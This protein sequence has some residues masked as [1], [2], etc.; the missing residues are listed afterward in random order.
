MTQAKDLKMQA[1]DI[2]PVRC[3]VAPVY[4]TRTGNMKHLHDTIGRDPEFGFRHGE[5][6]RGRKQMPGYLMCFKPT[7]TSTCGAGTKGLRFDKIKSTL[8]RFGIRVDQN[9]ILKAR[10]EFL[11][12]CPRTTSNEQADLNQFDRVMRKLGMND[13]YIS[14]RVFKCFDVDESGYVD[15]KE[16]CLGLTAAWESTLADK[17]V[18][19]FNVIDRDGDGMLERDE[20]EDLLIDS[21]QFDEA[22]PERTLHNVKVMVNLIFDLIDPLAKGGGISKER[23]LDGLIIHPQ[24]VTILDKCFGT[25]TKNAAGN[26]MLDR[27]KKLVG[28]DTKIDASGYQKSSAMQQGMW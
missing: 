27:A 20:I 24:V 11:S 5:G 2:D 26:T 23:F 21:H 3:G 14:D 8:L 19:Y 15:F 22:E 28:I 7:A 6:V 18:T 1:D 9:F 10:N 25:T 17:M 12:C 4:T 13:V 16:F